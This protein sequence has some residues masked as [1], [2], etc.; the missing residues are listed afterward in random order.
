MFAIIPGITTLSRAFTRRLV[1]LM[2]SS[3]E[4]K[5]VCRDER[6]IR[7]CRN[8]DHI[9]RHFSSCWPPRPRVGSSRLWATRRAKYPSP[10]GV[11]IWKQGVVLQQHYQ[12]ELQEFQKHYWHC[13]VLF[14]YRIN[15]NTLLLRYI[16]SCPLCFRKR[17]RSILHH[18]RDFSLHLPS[19]TFEITQNLKNLLQ[20]L[21]ITNSERIWFL[22]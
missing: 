15:P 8:S 10:L 6:R 13:R 7:T 5:E 4:M 16:S 3:K 2:A 18:F 11:S 20:K 17:N 1:T 9:L 14:D 22:F 12:C 19:K 21:S